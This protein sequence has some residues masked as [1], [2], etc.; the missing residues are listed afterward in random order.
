MNGAQP[1]G[2]MEQDD[3]A[4]P[5]RP[6]QGR[7][8][9]RASMKA[10]PRV[11]RRSSVTSTWLRGHLRDGQTQALG[12]QQMVIEGLAQADS[13]VELQPTGRQGVEV[14]QPPWGSQASTPSSMPSSRA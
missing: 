7:R 10:S 11:S 14:A 3:E 13:R 5:V 2:G 8:L 1:I 9:T 12:H 4:D 6:R